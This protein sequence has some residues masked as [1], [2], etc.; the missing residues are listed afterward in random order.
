M[1]CSLPGSS[2]HGIFQARVLE[3]VAISFSCFLRPTWFCIPGYL[4]LGEWSYYCDYL[5]HEDLFC[6]VLLCIL[7]SFS[8]LASASYLLL[9]LGPTLSVLYWAHL[10]MKCF[11]GISNFLEEISSLSHAIV[12]LY[13]FALIA[14]EGFLISCY[15]LDS[16]FRCLYLW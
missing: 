8:Y 10:C 12:F 7:A 11:L 1:D 13:F 4:V 2:A 14:K 3:W 9:L 15:S 6:T 16:A 5:G